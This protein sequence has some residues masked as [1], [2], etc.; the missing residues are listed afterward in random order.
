MTK[1]LEEWP[2]LPTLLATG[3]YK[4]LQTGKWWQGHFSR[5]GFTDG[6]TQGTRHGDQGLAVGRRTLQP[7]YDFVNT[8]H[9][10]RKPFFV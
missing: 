2:T 5:G 3:G 7:I 1:H 10:D 6:M 4:S 9:A 8:C